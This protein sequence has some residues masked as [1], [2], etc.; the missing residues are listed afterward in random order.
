VWL[1]MVDNITGDASFVPF[2]LYAIDAPAGSMLTIP[3]V[4]HTP[5]GGNTQWQTDVYTAQQ[6]DSTF[7]GTCTSQARLQASA[8]ARVTDAFPWTSFWYTQ[9]NDVARQFCDGDDIR[10]ALDL[11]SGSWTSAWARIYT[12]AANGGT[13]GEMMPPFPPRGWPVRHFAGIEVRG[14]TR[15]NVGLYNGFDAPATIELRLYT[16]SGTLAATRQIT[17]I[18]RESNQQ[19]LRALFGELADGIYALSVM[20]LDAAGCWPYVSTVDNTTGDPTNWW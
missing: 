15:V 7:H 18:A 3:A 1:S 9:F 14:E 11:R 16:A 13:F 8:G 20:P 5:G 2:S 17:L 10:G 12:T 19:P 4:A 6:T